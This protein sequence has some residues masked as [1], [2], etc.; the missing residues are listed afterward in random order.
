MRR[1]AELGE[2]V[3]RLLEGQQWV[4]TPSYK[5]E[6]VIG[7]AFN[8]LGDEG[9][10]VRNFL[11]GTWLGH[12]LHEVLTDFPVGAWTSA[13]VMDAADTVAPGRAGLVDGARASIGFG[14]VAAAGAAVT[15]LTDW[16]YT[17]D[18]A[19]RVG[20][21]HG[22]LNSLVLGVYAASWLERR[23]GQQARGR[24]L[25][26]GGYAALLTSAYLGGALVSRHR[27]G[28]DHA[29]RRL[30]PR[31]FTTVLADADLA[32]G[33]PR[34]VQ[35]EGVRVLLARIDGRVHAVGE[36]CAHQGGPLAE[37]WLYRD[38]IV[39]PWHGSRY[40]LATGRVLRGPATAPLPC[41]DTRVVGGQL[42]VR[43]RPPAP[44]ATPGSVVASEQRDDRAGH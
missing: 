6:H 36:R 27:V 3:V 42:Q 28:V 26:A 15:G 13:L 11:H 32:E 38:S 7:L 4:D 8:L 14:V 30:L 34:A 39:C 29:D 37:G 19:R 17:Q 33:A 23:R 24:A 31:E 5:V 12:P 22:L 9:A 35:V 18:N 41:F 21:A 1:P 25:A 2:W 44:T 40:D 20:A 43:C 10:R 16:Q